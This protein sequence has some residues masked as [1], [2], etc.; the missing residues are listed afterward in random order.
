M[1]SRVD[2]FEKKKNA[3]QGVEKRLEDILRANFAEEE[4][5]DR[6]R[7]GNESIAEALKE[8]RVGS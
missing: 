4:L 7:K 3:P 6:F 5:L 2:S 1:S 8:V